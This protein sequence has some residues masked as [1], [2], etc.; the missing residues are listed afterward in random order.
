MLE[1]LR[2][3]IPE[4]AHIWREI[5]HADTVSRYNQRIY[6]TSVY[7]L[8]TFLAVITSLASG[9][10]NLTPKHTIFCGISLKRSPNCISSF[11]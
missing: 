5:L 6:R 9:L 8:Q 7:C 3:E 11:L 4:D 2:E 10:T 1:D